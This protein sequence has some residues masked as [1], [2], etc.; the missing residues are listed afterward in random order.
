[1]GGAEGWARRVGARRV[2]GP[3]EGGPGEGVGVG[4]RVSLKSVFAS[5]DARFL[6]ENL[7]KNQFF[8]PSLVR[9]RVPFSGFLSL[10]D[11]TVF[12]RKCTMDETVFG[13]KCT[14]DETVFGRKCTMDET[15][16]GRKCHWMK[17]FL[18]DS[19]IG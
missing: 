11:E 6:V 19:V 16:F 4:R 3:A 8:E 17:P 12:G 7:V 2:G 9:G 18:D 5:I 10:V 15:M 13:R 14:M 1:M